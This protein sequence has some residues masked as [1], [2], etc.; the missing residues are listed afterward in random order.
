M[1]KSEVITSEK[2]Y[3]RSRLAF[4]RLDK[5]KAFEEGQ[6]PRFETSFLVDPSEKAKGSVPAN[7][8]GLAALTVIVKTAAKIAKAKW[9]VTPREVLRVAS[10]IGIPGVKY[11]PKAKD[12]KIK[13]DCLYSGDTKEYDGFAGNWVLATH[14]KNKPAVANRAGEAVLPG[15]DEFPFSGSFGR[16]SVTFWTQ[17]NKYGRRIGVNLRGVQWIRTG[18]AFGA[19]AIDPSDE[20]GALE[21]G[22]VDES[23]AE[24]A[25]F[26][27][28]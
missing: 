11:D 1:P 21:D 13:F 4:V 19:G 5:P 20:F 3:V 6:D 10:E 12:D 22:P 14:N 15:E 9:G 25:P 2:V 27:D 8:V 24:N 18:E 7:E 17:D 23:G 28:D 26:G 16:G